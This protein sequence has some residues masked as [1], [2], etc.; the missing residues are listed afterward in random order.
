MWRRKQGLSVPVSEWINGSLR[1]EV[2]RLFEPLRLRRQ[3]MLDPE[4]ISR[5]LAEH[6]EGHNDHG[7][8]LWPLFILQRWYERWLEGTPAAPESTCT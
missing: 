1:G 4:P 8:R 6:R 7:R 2:D 5:M 3:E